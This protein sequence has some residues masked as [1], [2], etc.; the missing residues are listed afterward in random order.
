MHS[1]AAYEQMLHRAWRAVYDAQM[2]A[3]TRSRRNHVRKLKHACVVVNECYGDLLD[4]M[5][6]LEAQ[7]VLDGKELRTGGRPC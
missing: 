1:E 2:Y 3:E 7:R 4:T 6:L 5:K